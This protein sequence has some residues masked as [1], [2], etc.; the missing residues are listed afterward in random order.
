[1]SV[2]AAAAAG[3]RQGKEGREEGGERFNITSFPSVKFF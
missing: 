3:G 1:M 2:D